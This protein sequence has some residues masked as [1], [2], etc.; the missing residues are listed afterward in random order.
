MYTDPLSYMEDSLQKLLK[1]AFLKFPDNLQQKYFLNL[2]SSV[3]GLRAK[4][5]ISNEPVFLRYANGDGK[6]QFGEEVECDF[7]FA[8]G[9]PMSTQGISF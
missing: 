7:L 4:G 5:P 6:W 3:L 1:E 9:D 8:M 2:I